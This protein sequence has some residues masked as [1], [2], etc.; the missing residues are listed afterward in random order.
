MNYTIQMSLNP[1]RKSHQY[2]NDAIMYD[3]PPRSAIEVMR[4]KDS[5][6]RNV[7]LKAAKKDLKNKI[8]N[9]TLYNTSKVESNEQFTLTQM[10][11]S[12][13]VQHAKEEKIHIHRR[14][15]IPI[16]IIYSSEDV[17]I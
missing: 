7:W 9:G 14:H 8:Y 10:Q 17:S 15:I 11:N 2:G 5:M 16:V 1:Y 4:T 12:W 3:P 6:K 13:Q